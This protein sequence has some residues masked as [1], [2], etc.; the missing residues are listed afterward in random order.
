MQK[1]KLANM[2]RD[3]AF[4]H[5]SDLIKATFST[6]D[7]MNDKASRAAAEYAKRFAKNL[8]TGRNLFFFGDIGTG[9]TFL[10]AAVINAAIDEGYK[11]LFSSFPQEINE[12]ANTRDKREY[13]QNLKSYDF[14]VFDDMG[15]ERE[16][17]FNLEQIYQ[18]VNTRHLANKPMII[19]TNMDNSEFSCEDTAK[20]RIF[21]RIFEKTDV[22]LMDG[23]DRRKSKRR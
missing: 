10:A 11:C 6:D 1:K 20:R 14:I 5:G 19:T 21:S 15:T 9:K 8:E 18:I 12:I 22:I 7:K 23:E 13:F 3:W 2:H 17:E 16:T 4:P